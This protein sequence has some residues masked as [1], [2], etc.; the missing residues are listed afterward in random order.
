MIV[1]SLP[2]PAAFL[3]GHASG[4]EFIPARPMVIEFNMTRC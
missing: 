3:L 2:P 1:A 4:V